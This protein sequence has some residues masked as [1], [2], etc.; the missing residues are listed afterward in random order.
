MEDAEALKGCRVGRNSSLK[1][2]LTSHFVVIN[3][4]VLFPT[5]PFTRIAIWIL[6]YL[7]RAPRSDK[8][9]QRKKSKKFLLKIPHLQLIT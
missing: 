1:D 4:L 9:F 5:G 2:Q 6:C 7:W 3:V 8:E